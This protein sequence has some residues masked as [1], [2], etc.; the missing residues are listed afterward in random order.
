VWA[1]GIISQDYPIIPTYPGRDEFKGV[2]YHAGEHQD[3]AAMP[4]VREK[5]VVVIGSGTTAHDVCQDYFEAG[6]MVTMLQR[7]ATLVCSHE[8]AVK[9]AMPPPAEG[10]TNEEYVFGLR[11]FPMLVSFEIMVQATQLMLQFDS[12]LIKGLDDTEFV[13]SK[14]EGGDS[15]LRR[16]VTT[17]GGFYVNHGASDLIAAKKINVMH[18][19]GGV[20]AISASGVMLADGRTAP[21][22]I[23][24]AATGWHNIEDTLA[25]VIGEDEAKRASQVYHAPTIDAEGQPPGM[26]RPSGHPG[27]W[28]AGGNLLG[29]TMG[30]PVLALQILAVELGLNKTG[31]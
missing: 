20:T 27:F 22:D 17:R 10:Q 5:R 21:A 2:F 24:V 16:G 8:A 18:C 4:N 9:F 29:S 31:R 23:I 26:F 12:E 6:A 1:C 15:F 30:A 11:S 7:S 3:A 28:V 14:G 25:A 19:P 13:V